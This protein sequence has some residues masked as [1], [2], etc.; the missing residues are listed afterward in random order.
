M[1]HNQNS[2][3]IADLVFGH[4][5]LLSNLFILFTW[6]VGQICTDKNE[7]VLR[8]KEILRTIL[9]A[10]QNYFSNKLVSGKPPI[11]ECSSIG[12]DYM[13]RSEYVLFRKLY[14]S[15]MDSIN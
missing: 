14:S 6:Q 15:L 11:G 2:K 1:K 9:N 13:M 5:S 12:P 10:L 3:L 7:L 4:Y 8:S